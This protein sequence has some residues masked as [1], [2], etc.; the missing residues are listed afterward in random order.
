MRLDE[1]KPRG[2]RGKPGKVSYGPYS[3]VA[4][5]SSEIVMNF[6]VWIDNR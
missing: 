2:S 6:F 1:T 3:D 4:K 5:A